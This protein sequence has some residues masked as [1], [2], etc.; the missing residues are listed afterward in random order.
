MPESTPLGRPLLRQMVRRH[1]GALAG[2]VALL[3]VWTAGEALVPAVVGATIDAAIA[4]PDPVRLALWIG[5]LALTFASL[6]YGFRYGARIANRIVNQETHGLRTLVAGRALD[7]RGSASQK[8][9]G[10][11][12]ALASVDAEVAG[13]FVRQLS[14]AFSSG[15]GLLVCAAYLLVT[16]LWLGLLVLVL[17]PLGLATLRAVTP[18]LS[19]RTG[20]Q[21]ESIADATG[22]VADLLRGTAVLQGVGG[23]E[24][25]SGWYAKRSALATRAAIRTAGPSGRMD[26]VQLLVSGLILAAVAGVGGWQVLEGN[27]SAGS[28]IGT[29]GVTAFLAT[30]LGG[31][32]ELAAGVARSRAAAERIGEYL[33]EPPL[34]TGVERPTPLATAPLELHLPGADGRSVVRIDGGT[35]TAVVCADATVSARFEEGFA[36]GDDVHE[37]LVNGVRYSDVD[38]GHAHSVLRIPPHVP[39]V[40]E[41]SLGLNV[42]GAEGF[43]DSDGAGAESAGAESAGVAPAEA[44]PAKAAPAKAAPADGALNNPELWRASGV[45]QLLSG[46]PQ[47][48]EHQLEAD[49]NNLSGGQ[50]QRVALA[51]A[52]GGAAVPRLL[53]DPTTAVDSVTEAGIASGLSA[54][55]RTPGGQSTLAVLTTS[56]ALAAVAQQVAFV[57]LEGAVHTGT[58]H[59]LS[60][61]PSYLEVVAR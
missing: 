60:A 43:G 15:L 47:G 5:V 57:D 38:P 37:V 10:Q 44:A 11:I 50:L 18:L 4:V 12:A 6:S 3:S 27:M 61:L 35:F 17:V 48:L 49:G 41:G 8:L 7:P 53:I 25:A 16:D 56:P 32:V 20:E 40:F 31:L 19:R 1:R 46:L 22:S 28:L 13:G 14:F 39:Q 21:Q 30:P 55:R 42:H 51:R 45:D 36:A 9:P 58:H 52:L 59:E 24:E 33:A 23:E 2:S 34:R 26:A 54:W 29:L